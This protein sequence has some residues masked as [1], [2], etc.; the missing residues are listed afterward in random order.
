[1]IHVESNLTRASNLWAKTRFNEAEML[2]YVRQARET[3]K[4][5]IGSS[6]VRN[7]QKKMAYFF[8][9]LKDVL[10]LKQAKS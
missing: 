5:R 9:V 3:T 7:R 2:A 8:R 1:M 6:S 10:G 4:Q